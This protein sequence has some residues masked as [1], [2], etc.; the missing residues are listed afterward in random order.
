MTTQAQNLS[1][2]IAHPYLTQTAP[3]SPSAERS[4]VFSEVPIYRER[5]GARFTRVPPARAGAHKPLHL[6]RTLYKSSLF[7]QNKPNFPNPRINASSALTKHYENSRLPT[8]RKNKPNPSPI[9]LNLRV[10]QINLSHVNISCY[11]NR[12]PPTRRKNKPN[13]P[14]SQPP[15]RNP[16]KTT[17]P[18]P[19]LRHLD[20]AQRVEKS[21]KKSQREAIRRPLHAP[22]I[23]A[24]PPASRAGAAGANTA[25][26]FAHFPELFAQFFKVF[27]RFLQ[28]SRVFHVFDT[29]FR[30]PKPPKCPTLPPAP[31]KERLRK[32]NLPIYLPRLIAKIY[33][34]LFCPLLLHQASPSFFLESFLP[35]CERDLGLF[36]QGFPLK[37]LCQQFG[38]SLDNCVT[39]FSL[40]PVALAD[41]PEHAILVG[42]RCQSCKYPLFLII[43]QDRAIRNVEQEGDSRAYLID[44]LPAGTGA[45]RILENQLLFAN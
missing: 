37:R 43:R 3:L 35:G 22:A 13:Q 7:M 29:P 18:Q 2:E 17:T 23:P 45:S 10:A 31:T 11:E 34:S 12:R 26:F 44:F 6:S 15:H 32:K 30:S 4:E 27:A 21:I 41:D 24:H 36:P 40:C 1:R 38:E 14:Q 19:A 33:H 9:K 20:R 5:A 28:N 8:P 25:T 16:S 42:P 39:V